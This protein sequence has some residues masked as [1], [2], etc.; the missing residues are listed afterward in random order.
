VRP[1]YFKLGLKRKQEQDQSFFLLNPK[2]KPSDFPYQELRSVK[3]Q[4]LDRDYKS[5]A[6]TEKNRS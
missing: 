6:I 4:T 1:D 2:L 5:Q 3:P